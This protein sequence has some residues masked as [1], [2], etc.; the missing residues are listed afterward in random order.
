MARYLNIFR[1]AVIFILCTAILCGTFAI[2]TSENQMWLWSLS[3]VLSKL[4][5][6]VAGFALYAV[7]K[8]WKEKNIESQEEN[9]RFF[10]IED[11]ETE[12]YF[13]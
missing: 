7:L 9:R 5:A 11:D 3:L 13:V 10:G 4:I 6:L 12:D 1:I 8:Y 2:P